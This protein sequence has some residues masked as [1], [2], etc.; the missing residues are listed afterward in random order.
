MRRFPIFRSLSVVTLVAAMAVLASIPAATHAAPRVVNGSQVTAEQYE[1]RWS[2]IAAL[3]FRGEADARKGQFCA[4]TFIAPTLVVTAAHCVADSSKLL[5]LDDNGMM[6][7]FNAQRAI[8]PASIQ[9][10]A[11]RRILSVRNGERLNVTHV[12]VHPRYDPETGINDVALVQLAKAPADATHVTPVLPVQAGEDAI[13]GD[14]QG[15]ATSDAL[16]P[17]IAGWGYRSSPDYGFF[18]GAS[19][20]H[21]MHRPTHPNRPYRPTAKGSGR[22]SIANALEA[23]GMPIRSDAVCDAGALGQGTGYGRTYDSA[24]ML[25]AG[26]LNTADLNDFNS[27]NN[28][29]D[30]CYGDSGGPM[31]ASTGSALRLVGIVSFGAGC[32]DRNMYGVYTRVAAMRTFLTSQPRRN[33]RVRVKPTAFGAGE[34]GSVLSCAPGRWY[35]AGRVRYSY[36]WVKSGDYESAIDGA[37]YGA[38][39]FWSRIPGS[40]GTRHYRVQES[41][42]GSSIA[43]LVVATNGQTTAAENSFPVDIE[44]DEPV[45]PED[46]PDDSDS[47]FDY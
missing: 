19:A 13:W 46:E 47:D 7:R 42:A 43:C 37:F 1:A 32:A 38:D 30:A 8:D 25:C 3:A 34:V 6:R 24:S 18:T 28:G 20:A 22:E 40:A 23:V 2:S 5:L 21:P 41:D 45:D 16:G 44:G 29:V 9:V 36:R 4:S 12:L 17:W 39:E 27:V 31:L 26:V 14:G 15:R 10:I 33:V 11:G 35:G